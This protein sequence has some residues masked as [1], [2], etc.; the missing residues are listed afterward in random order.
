MDAPLLYFKLQTV[1]LTKQLCHGMDCLMKTR[2]KK[3][4][5]KKERKK[6]DEERKKETKN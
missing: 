5:T 1:N 2:R 4:T 3:K 6:E